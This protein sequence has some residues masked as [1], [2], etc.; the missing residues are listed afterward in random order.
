[1]ASTLLNLVIMTVSSAFGTS[2]TIPLGT[3][4]TINGVTYLSFANGGATGGNQISY[5]ILDSGGAG[6]SETGT[7][8]YTSSNNTL[9]GRTPTQSTNGSTFINA[10]SA[11]LIY[12]VVRAQDIMPV[13]TQ[14]T[15]SIS[16]DITIPPSSGGYADGPTVAQGS[17]GVWFAS[18]S[19]MV[20]DTTMAAP[21]FFQLWDG[22]TVIGSG[23]INTAGA[24]FRET[25]TLSGYITNP[26]GNI[27][28]SATNASTSAGGVMRANNTGRGK[29]STITVFRIG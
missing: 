5:S 9:T 17:S 22:T 28:F 6:N 3:A 20:V 8:T 14:L 10:S 27:R 29:D 26:V 1:M 12:A 15:N 7:I 4:A 16:S 2:T 11:A 23:G 25:A 21:I 13:G 24:G 19:C 18:A